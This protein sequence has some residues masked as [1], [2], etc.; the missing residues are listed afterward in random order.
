LIIEYDI[1]SVPQITNASLYSIFLH[2]SHL[3]E[4]KCVNNA[5][6]NDKGIPDLAELL[7]EDDGTDVEDLP[8][9]AKLENQRILPTAAT[10]D[11]LRIVDF[12]GCSEI[13]DLAIDNLVRN[14]PKLRHL[15]LAKCPLITDMA[16]ESIARLGRSLHHLHL[17][18]AAR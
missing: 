5:N 12:M 2:S 7:D 11:Y 14:A 4:L 13:N 9:Y 15:S 16:L 1:S 3:R 6:I 10:F 8:W 18:H 17:G